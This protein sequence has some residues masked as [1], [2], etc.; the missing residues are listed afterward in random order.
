MSVA[1]DV[2]SRRERLSVGGRGSWV[3]VMSEGHCWEG[4]GVEGADCWS[5][6]DGVDVVVLVVMDE[7][8]V[9]SVS[10]RKISACVWIVVVCW[11]KI[12]CR[13]VRLL[14]CVSWVVRRQP[15]REFVSCKRSSDACMRA[16]VVTVRSS[17]RERTV[18]SWAP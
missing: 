5:E 17:M 7:V 8:V 11:S 15:M 16:A 10:V 18:S 6:E 2:E 14:A 3:V 1:R 12:C 13:V 9:L 4:W